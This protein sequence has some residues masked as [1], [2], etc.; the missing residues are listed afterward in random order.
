MTGAG[1]RGEVLADRAVVVRCAHGESVHYPLADI[2]VQ[3]AG[4]KFIVQAGVLEQSIK[5]AAIWIALNER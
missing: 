2:A 5:S 3:I 1:T 4:R